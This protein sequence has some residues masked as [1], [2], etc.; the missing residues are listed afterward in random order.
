MENVFEQM[1][2]GKKKNP[3]TMKSIK[4]M[5]FTH[6]EFLLDRFKK[7]LINLLRILINPIIKNKKIK[8]GIEI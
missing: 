8:I 6:K 3:I 5:F 1:N 7:L 2:N 4:S